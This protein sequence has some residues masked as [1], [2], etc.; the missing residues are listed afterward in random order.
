MVINPS[1]RAHVLP[2]DRPGL[3]DA[4]AVRQTGVTLYQATIAADP[5]SFG[6]FRL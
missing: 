3:A 2:H 5:F 4:T 1:G 6:I